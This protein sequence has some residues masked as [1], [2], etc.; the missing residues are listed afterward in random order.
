MNFMTELIAYLNGLLDCGVSTTVPEKR[1]TKAV[2]VV[3]TGGQST[4]FVEQPSITVHA[5]AKSDLEALQLIQQ[6]ADALIFYPDHSENVAHSTQESVYA[7]P[8]TDGTPRWSTNFS[9]VIN[10]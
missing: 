8:Y 9:F 4:R 3:R 2:T 1:P 7:N 5:W 6:V 10:R